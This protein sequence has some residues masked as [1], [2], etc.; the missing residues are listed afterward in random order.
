MDLPIVR[1]QK[2]QTVRACIY[3]TR[4]TPERFVGGE[5]YFSVPASRYE[6]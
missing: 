5:E 2:Q 6:L 3:M 4:N 1:E